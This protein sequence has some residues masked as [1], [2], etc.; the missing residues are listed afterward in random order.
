MKVIKRRLWLSVCTAIGAVLLLACLVALHETPSAIVAGTLAAVSL[1]FI[2]CNSRKLSSARLI[3]E[4]RMIDICPATVCMAGT[5]EGAT[6][7]AV[8][9]VLS[10]FGLLVENKIYKFGRDGVRLHSVDIGD[11]HITVCFSNE[12]RRWTA[13]LL[14][15]PLDKEDLAQLAKKME[16]E[17]GITPSLSGTGHAPQ[18]KE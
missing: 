4:N 13:R 16:Y 11:R 17:T 18:R 7:Q 9:C 2:V 14:Y 1:V 5:G 15:G 6:R 8:E 10:P 12:D 3:T